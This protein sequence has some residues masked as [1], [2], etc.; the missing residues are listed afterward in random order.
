[1]LRT[2]RRATSRDAWSFLDKAPEG[3]AI[4]S[5]RLSVDR[6]VQRGLLI[7]DGDDEEGVGTAFMQFP[8]TST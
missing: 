8:T 1:M 4:V 6:H 5:E 7:R 2:A 3:P